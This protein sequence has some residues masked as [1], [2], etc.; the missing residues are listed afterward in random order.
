MSERLLSI[1]EVAR[2]LSVV[3]K[4]VRRNLT[5]LK[6][7]GLQQVPLG[8]K[9]IRFRESSLNRIIKRAA[10]REENLFTVNMSSRS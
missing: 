2:R 1:D 9:S 4:T 7:N 3:P 8:T 5:K 6:A 10:E